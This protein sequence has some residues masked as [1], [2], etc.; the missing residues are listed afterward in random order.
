AR[1]DADAVLARTDPDAFLD[2][3]DLDAVLARV[4]LDAVADRVDVD[5]IARRIDPDALLARVDLAAWA[6][7][8]LEEL[9]VG[10]IVRDTGGSITAETLDA[11]RERNAR[12]DGFVDRMTDRLLHRHGPDEAGRR[13]KAP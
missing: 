4:D 3:V 9:D 12:A 11:F 7:Q 6:E 2:R 5:R 13:G 10:R 8:V 1:I